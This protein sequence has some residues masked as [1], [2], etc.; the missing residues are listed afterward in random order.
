M[1]ADKKRESILEST[2]MKN[3]TIN[4]KTLMSFYFFDV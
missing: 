1:L 4:Y 2:E 3:L